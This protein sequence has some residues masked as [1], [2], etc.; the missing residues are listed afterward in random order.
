MNKRKNLRLSLLRQTEVS[1]LFDMC[2][3]WKFIAQTRLSVAGIGLR[4][5]G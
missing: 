1:F 3:G 5:P 2:G 4:V